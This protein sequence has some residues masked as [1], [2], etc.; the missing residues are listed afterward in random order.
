MEGTLTDCHHLIVCV[1]VCVCI[2]VYV[3]VHTPLF[4]AV[5]EKSNR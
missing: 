3:R 2:G 5:H 1:C 4:K